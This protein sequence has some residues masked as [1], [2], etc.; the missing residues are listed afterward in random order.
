M[1]QAFSFAEHKEPRF[2]SIS[3]LESV[4]ARKMKRRTQDSSPLMERLL[5]QLGQAHDRLLFH[6]KDEWRIP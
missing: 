3:S 1:K 6:T 4:I 2:L 5:K